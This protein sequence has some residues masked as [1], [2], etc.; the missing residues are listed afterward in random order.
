MEKSKTETRTGKIHFAVAGTQR[1]AERNA[2]TTRSRR[3]YCARAGELHHDD[4][5]NDDEK[6]KKNG[7]KARIINQV[8]RK[9]KS[10]RLYSNRRAAE[11]VGARK[12]EATATLFISLWRRLRFRRTTATATDIVR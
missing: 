8:L 2:I 1:K 9:V 7:K 12:M 5:D 3:K 4:D 6:K 10:F 11:V